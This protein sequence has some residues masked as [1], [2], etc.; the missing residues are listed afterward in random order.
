MKKIFP[1]ML[2]TQEHQE[3]L[4]IVARWDYA[5]EAAIESYLL[6]KK[7]SDNVAQA[8][9]KGFDDGRRTIESKEENR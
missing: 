8:Y 2:T 7:R 5:T 3:I 1:D 4:R 9:Q 6:G